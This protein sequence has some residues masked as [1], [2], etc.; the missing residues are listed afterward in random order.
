MER[1]NQTVIKLAQTALMAA[2]CY[3]S[4]T[5]LQLKIPLPGGAATSYHIGNDF[6]VLG[7]PVR[8]GG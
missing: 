2:L 6:C 1:R 5:F 8:G 4:F 3:G 7:G